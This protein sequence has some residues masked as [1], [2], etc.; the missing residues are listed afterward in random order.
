MG[1]FTTRTAVQAHE[2]YLLD[3]KAEARSAASR[4]AALRSGPPTS[5]RTASPDFWAYKE[6]NGVNVALAFYRE[7]VHAGARRACRFRRDGALS[8]ELKAKR[9]P[10]DKNTEQHAH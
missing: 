6:A 1:R 10:H 5:R 8:R 3:L 7:L 4:N 9:P 2:D